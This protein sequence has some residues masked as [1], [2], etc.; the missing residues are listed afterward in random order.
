MGIKQKIFFTILPIA[1]LVVV[2]AYLFIEPQLKKLEIN[3]VVKSLTERMNNLHEKTN[4]ISRQS[5]E[6]ASLFGR[7]PE[8]VKAFRLARQGNMDDENDEFAQ[9]ARES[10]RRDLG[11]II[12]NY[13]KNTGEKL[14]VHFHL[15]N[16]RSLVRLWRKKQVTRKG[17]ALDI[18]DDLSTFRKTVMDVNR[19][20]Q[21]RVGIE[22]GRN[23][24]SI[25]AV[26][27]V[28]DEKG[29]RLGSV[30]VIKEYNAIFSLL[31]DENTSFV[32]FMDASL[33]PITTSLHDNNKYPVFEE[34]FVTV[35]ASKEDFLQ[36]Y[37]DKISFEDLKRG[38]KE[39]HIVI[40]SKAAMGFLPVKDY[41]D[42]PVGIIV[43]R[44]DISA[45]HLFIK[46][47]TNLINLIFLSGV[48]IIVILVFIQ[49][50]YMV[51]RPLAFINQSVDGIAQGKL[52]KIKTI[53]TKD[54]IAQI[55]RAI[56]K[57]PNILQSV[58]SDCLHLA[59]EVQ[60]GRISVVGNAEKY[61][62]SY[63][64]LI[65]SINALAGS[66]KRTFETLPIPIFAMDKKYSILYAN[67]ATDVVYCTEAQK[68]LPQE[69]E[70]A[71]VDPDN[72]ALKNVYKKNIHFEKGEKNQEIEAY[73]IPIYDEYKKLQGTWIVL[74]DLTEIIRT[75][76]LI[77]ETAHSAKGLAEQMNIS[78]AQLNEQIQ[79]SM[80]GAQLQAERT[81]ASASA[82]KEM[83]FSFQNIAASTSKAAEN[84]ERSKEQAIS[85]KN[86]VGNVVVTV[87]NIMSLAEQLKNNMEDL[88][89]K[90]D[91]IGRI[92]TVITDIADQTNLLALNAA[93]EAARAGESGRGFSV[94]ADEVRKLAEKTMAATL[95]VDETV[96][97]I[98][99][100]TK[101]NI[102]DS[103]QVAAGVSK[104]SELAE[105]AER[106][107]N[108]ILEL[109]ITAA[110]QMAAIA[111]ATEQQTA[112]T[113]EIAE[114][115]NDIYQVA[116]ETDEAM[117]VSA[118]NC[119]NIFEI[120]QKL[121]NIISRLDTEK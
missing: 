57:I 100:A 118:K 104:G 95:E 72:C 97:S 83:R 68:F 35:A 12:A 73:L 31:R 22:L 9:K 76:Q 40:G 69:L 99:K 77:Q 59:S 84:A 55:G 119:T 32:L 89:E 46:N 29:Q 87:R 5:L 33:L 81:T 2:A 75:Q 64:K 101:D 70:D 86:A 91:N 53:K 47:V 27:Q 23:G 15:P 4:A 71:F 110:A 102:Y 41:K 93:I 112:I 88:G 62:G 18:S 82:I 58:I 43:I 21:P 117:Q 106:T 63:A 30:E 120:A 28:T 109:S 67:P 74:I 16:G 115:S 114:S 49:F 65:T 37:G 10:L 85:G 51:C 61:S 8:A 38:L 54:E 116:Q 79:K 92:L 66:F 105:E 60:S 36:T 11:T 20:G 50:L 80:N 19:D 52:M 111:A 48:A 45:S 78:S 108:E 103:E 14:K 24:F 90:A 96:K 44:E 17:E 42:Y 6:L 25:R 26:V 7:S 1:L 121:D 3:F 56:N 94:V 34:E 13:E 107:L 39:Q 98:Q 113:E